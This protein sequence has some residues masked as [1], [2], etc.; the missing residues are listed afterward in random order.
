MGLLNRIAA[1][2]A[3]RTDSFSG[4]G[5][6]GGLGGLEAG[7]IRRWPIDRTTGTPT[8]AAFPNLDLVRRRS[9]A[10][11]VNNPYMARAADAWPSA[12]IGAGI[13]TASSHADPALRKL[14]QAAFAA[15]GLRAAWSPGRSGKRVRRSGTET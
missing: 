1:R 10:A 15:W 13:V 3:K 6:L 9:V 2:L 11:T 14:L 7:S 4:L 8:P 12:A 5:A